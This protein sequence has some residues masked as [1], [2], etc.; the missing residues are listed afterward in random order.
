MTP[1]L[2]DLDASLLDHRA[3]LLDVLLH[4]LGE[5]LGG[6]A[7]RSAAG[8]FQLLGDIRQLDR[9][10]N[11]PPNLG[12]DRGRRVDGREQAGPG[13]RVVAPSLSA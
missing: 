4:E 10:L 12:D 11:R 6:I 5:V 8:R 1:R 2:L 13:G 9:A 7:D 3:P